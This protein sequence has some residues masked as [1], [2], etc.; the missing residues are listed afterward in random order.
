MINRS[1]GVRFVMW[2]EIMNNNVQVKNM[3]NRSNAFDLFIM[4][5]PVHYYSLFPAT[6]QIVHHL[7]YLSNG[8]QF[9]MWQE[10]INN[11][12]VKT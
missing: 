12:Q 6:L 8:V 5:L 1:N 4:F 11:V 3:I 10:I 2:Q 7:T 9:V